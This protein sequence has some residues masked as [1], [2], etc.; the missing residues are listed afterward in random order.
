MVESAAKEGVI[1]GEAGEGMAVEGGRACPACSNVANKVEQALVT[2]RKG[3]ILATA[4][5][6]EE[7][8]RRLGRVVPTGVCTAS[9]RSGG[10]DKK[11]D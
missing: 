8:L 11:P 1:G 2:L 7:L 9:S 10:A 3:R 5:S 4:K 6:L